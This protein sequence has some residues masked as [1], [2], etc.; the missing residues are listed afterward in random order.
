MKSQKLSSALLVCTMLCGV[1][2]WA[3]A[4]KNVFVTNDRARA[5]CLASDASLKG[6]ALVVCMENLQKNNWHPKRHPDAT[7]AAAKPKSE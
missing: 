1:G 7:E 4:A 3:K 2:A 6:D 5:R